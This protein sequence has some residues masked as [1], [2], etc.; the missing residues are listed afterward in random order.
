V[1]NGNITVRGEVVPIYY[2]FV[3]ENYPPCYLLISGVTNTGRETKES[4]DI[5]TGITF[6]IS[7]RYDNNSGWECD[8]I[9]S[10]LYQLAYPD[11]ETIIPGCLS[12][13]LVNDITQ[14]DYDDKAKKQI[15]ERTII[16]NHIITKIS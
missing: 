3:P 13:N 12:M 8:Q 1:L 11:R 14:A 9:A 16:F 10:Q 2:Q 6:T 15:I 7:T 4:Q 5:N